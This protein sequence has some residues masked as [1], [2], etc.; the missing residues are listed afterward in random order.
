MG[1]EPQW[2][3][4]TTPEDVS[5]RTV[6][7]EVDYNDVPAWADDYLSDL[8]ATSLLPRM[9]WLVLVTRRAPVVCQAKHLAFYVHS[10][11]GDNNNVWTSVATMARENAISPNTVRKAVRVL[12]VNGW[13]CIQSRCK[14]GSW[15]RDTNLYTPTWPTV[16]VI[17]K[18]Y[19]TGRER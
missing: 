14:P 12:Y 3:K 10:R 6:H 8:Q 16:D 9:K 13:L 11:L 5:E 15:E 7:R 1:R 4:S 18:P 2:P 17:A 19:A